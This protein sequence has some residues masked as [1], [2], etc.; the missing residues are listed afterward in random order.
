MKM[1]DSGVWLQNS[2]AGSQAARLRIPIH[3]ITLNDEEQFF[4]CIRFQEKSIGMFSAVDSKGSLRCKLSLWGHNDR[5]AEIVKGIYIPNLMDICLVWLV[6]FL[7]SLE[8]SRINHIHKLTLDE[9]INDFKDTCG[10]KPYATIIDTM[11][12][13][14]NDYGLWAFER[15]R[16]NFDKVRKM[17]RAF[18]EEA[19]NTTGNS[20]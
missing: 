20:K 2:Y 19:I 12:E 3:N 5:S 10:E 13:L 15:D 16:M 4:A 9:L 6:A 18:S 11:S 17:L 7:V 14:D 1:T 8:A